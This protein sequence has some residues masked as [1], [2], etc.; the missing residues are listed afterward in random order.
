VRAVSF[1]KG[2]E[3]RRTDYLTVKLLSAEGV[4][5]FS[6]FQIPFSP[7]IEE[8]Y[9]NELL[10]RNASGALVSTGRLADYYVLDER[11]GASVTTR[12]VL[13]I[14]VSGLQPDCTVELTVTRRDVGAPDEF[15]F[16]PFAFARAEPTIESVLYL[17]GDTQAVRYASSAGQRPVSI[18]GGL[19][20]RWEKPQ[21]VRWEPFLPLVCDYLPTVWLGDAS[22]RWPDIVTNY[23]GAIRDRF[24][25]SDSDRELALKL[26]RQC[27]NN[28]QKIAAIAAYVQTNYTYKAIEFG[29]R[30]RIPQT[31]GEIIRNKYGD[32]KD[33]A[34]L[35]QQ[36]LTAC[37]VPASLALVNV[38]SVI[39]EDVPSLDQF[40]HMIVHIPGATGDR[41]LDCT[42]KG[43][44]LDEPWTPGL[45]GRQALVLDERTPRFIR[46]AE[47]PTNASWI[48]VDRAI[49]FTNQTETLVREVL[50]F[51][52]MHAGY[53]RDFLAAMSPAGRHAYVGGQ[54]LS[55]SSE[56]L[57][58][59]ISALDEPLKPLELKLTYRMRGQFHLVQGQ[60]V[61]SLPLDVERTYLAEEPIAKRTLPFQVAIPLL[62]D[63]AVSVS[64]PAGYKAE[65]PHDLARAISNR[66]VNCNSTCESPDQNLRFHFHLYRPAGR[67][68]PDEY[69]DHSRAVQDAIH[70]LEPRLVAARVP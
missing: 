26:T 33:H 39:R 59:T 45:A 47:Y 19:C 24:T 36:L 38:D 12:K 27:T 66:Y 22:A 30:A 10:V 61:G 17:T 67:F 32:C 28:A 40:D 46:I 11:Q 1:K 53:L 9:V 31:T 60:F 70:Q 57:D 23:L 69:G 49:Q 68:A 21:T 37:G 65:L 25:L 51:G 15:T 41:F 7:L 16:L 6:T 62:I 8:V 50:V 13:N 54:L 18:E 52:G 55:G 63:G 14:P 44:R 48:R 29:R 43:F 2:K 4:S 3:L 64:V 34:L 5:Q 20:W 58:F 35:A 42:A 56:L